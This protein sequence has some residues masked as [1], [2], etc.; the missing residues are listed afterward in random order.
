MLR[1]PLRSCWL[2]AV[3]TFAVPSVLANTELPATLIELPQIGEPADSAM[4]PMEERR[5]GREI[6]SQLYAYDYVDEDPELTDYV[7]RMGWRL[8]E[9]SGVSTP[10]LRFFVIADDRINAFALPGGFIGMNRGLL[11]AAQRESEVA[12]VMGHEL[13]HV[14]QRHI[15]RTQEGTQTA[16]L[17]TW[18]A[19]LAAIIAGSAD[20]DLVIGALS[21]GQA[22]NYQRQV[23]YTR[24]H[25]LEADRIGIQ[26]LSRAGYD[27][28]G[29][30]SFFGT[31][32]QQSRLYGSTL[33]EFLRTHPLNTTRVAE[34]KSRAAEM[35]AV[36]YRDSLEF[37]LMQA[38][39]R[40]RSYSR[41]SLA[42]SYYS[43]SLRAGQDTPAIRY[44]MAL[45]Q[46]ALGQ[47][48][49]ALS[50]L[51]KALAANPRQ[52]NLLL[53][54]GAALR[55][56]HRLDES[57][58]VLDRTLGLYPRY[59]PAIFAY[60]EALMDAGRA[61][62]ARKILLAHEQSLGTQVKTYRMLAEA[63]QESGDLAE[64]AYQMGTYLAVR[65]DY[66]NA[67]AQLD[68][69][70]RL[71]DLDEQSRARL[72]AKRKEVREALPRNWR[73]P[74][75]Q[76]RAAGSSSLPLGEQPVVAVGE[77]LR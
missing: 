37:G 10:D 24:A 6:V 75:P 28:H 22:I 46:V 68:A 27:P 21:L 3:I 25:E 77:H 34:A 16:T 69:G 74:D 51:D 57:L 17:A 48:E 19:V 42:L 45:A 12:G 73:P 40:V 5:L 32:E 9:A 53:A 49:A 62:E 47:P 41:P 29:M 13:A 65:G 8:A 55:S 35:P 61:P 50:S 52:V 11:L 30:A 64:A 26:T 18:A 39:A 71:K 4:S 14:T 59:S 67:L 70:L 38:R 56:A 1:S 58:E 66:G 60:A 31:L 20:P 44:G 76:R 36:D 72:A 15:A 23:N 7:A 2:A 54:R 43:Q 33:P 63:A